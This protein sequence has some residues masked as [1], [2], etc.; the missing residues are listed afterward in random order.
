MGAWIGGRGGIIGVSSSAGERCDAY[1]SRE[2]V[3]PSGPGGRFRSKATA[4]ASDCGD[5]GSSPTTERFLQ[6]DEVTSPP[7][8]VLECGSNCDCDK[9]DGAVLCLGTVC[10]E[11]KLPGDNDEIEGE[12][13]L[14]TMAMGE[15]ND[16]LVTDDGDG[17]G[18]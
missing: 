12:K 2:T 17:A 10:G 6:S 13:E 7:P 3:R 5:S 11:G 1:S 18:V 15:S 4:D 16:N 8:P 14:G 9:G